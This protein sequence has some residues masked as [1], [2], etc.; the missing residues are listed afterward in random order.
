MLYGLELEYGTNLSDVP[1]K[2]RARR[3]INV[4]SNCKEK[5]QVLKQSKKIKRRNIYYIVAK[6]FNT[7][8][9]SILNFEENSFLT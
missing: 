1:V 3:P 8:K 4:K 6:L 9:A 2:S 7:I 5:T